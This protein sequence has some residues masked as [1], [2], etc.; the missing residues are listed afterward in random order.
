MRSAIVE[1]PHRPA[2]PTDCVDTGRLIASH[3][4]GL[5]DVPA[6]RS[7][8]RHLHLFTMPSSSTPSAQKALL[9][10]AC[11]NVF[12]DH[13]VDLLDSIDSVGI[14]TPFDIGLI[15][16]GITAEQHAALDRRGVHV[17]PGRWPIEPPARQ[18]QL[19]LIGHGGK[20]F[21][22]DFFPGYD[23]YVWIDADMWVQTPEFWTHLIDGAWHHG[24]AVPLETDPDY[25]RLAWSVRLWM[26][27]HFITS[28]GPLQALSLM[29]APMVNNGLF[30]LRGDAPQWDLWQGRYRTMV[31]RTQRTLAIDQLA[32]IAMLAFDKPDAM[33]LDATHNWVCSLAIP[34]FDTAAQRFI[35]PGKSAETIHVMHVTTPV[36][37]SRFP[38]RGSD[39]SIM[40]RWLHRPQGLVIDR[41]AA[42]VREMTVKTKG[43]TDDAVSAAT[44]R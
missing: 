36:R 5:T 11:S 25:Q 6:I 16:L 39:G 31:D 33:L 22:R 28:W 26:M 41:L 43:L 9:V 20:P 21:A 29:R 15:D 32:M 40:T 27:R 44:E 24:L 7:H 12:F 14:A 37:T 2:D 17:V 38:V 42:Q 10:T 1:C 35:K 30:A 34:A 23:I 13:Y 8:A 4:I 19:H 3:S 18:N